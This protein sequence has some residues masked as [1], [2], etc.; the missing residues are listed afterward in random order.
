MIIEKNIP[1]PESRKPG[2]S[3]DKYVIFSEMT[4]G[5]S[6][7]VTGVKSASVAHQARA[8]GKDAGWKFIVRPVEGGVRVWRVK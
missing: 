5:D 3:A 6:V 4:V 2:R 8:I 1:I 7:M